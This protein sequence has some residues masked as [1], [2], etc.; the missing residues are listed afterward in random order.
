[1]EPAAGERLTAALGLDHLILAGPDLAGLV[2]AFEAQ[3]GAGG[4]TTSTGRGG[5][6]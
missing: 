5:P 2:A 1:M 6:C 3:T 4:T